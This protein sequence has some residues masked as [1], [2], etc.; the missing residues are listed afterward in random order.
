MSEPRVT[1]QSPLHMLESRMSRQPAYTMNRLLSK[2]LKTVTLLMEMDRPVGIR[3]IMNW[4][5][6]K[7]LKPVTQFMDMDR[8]VG[9]RGIM[10]RLLVYILMILDSG[11][12]SMSAYFSS[13]LA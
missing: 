13:I 12:K 5:L 4:F 8:L 7:M 6:V 2:I 10:N 3:G 1:T 9:I 11:M